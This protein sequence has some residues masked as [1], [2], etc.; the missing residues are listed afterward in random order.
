MA[1]SAA[2]SADCDGGVRRGV[3]PRPGPGLAAALARGAGCGM[4]GI[5]WA[6][7]AGRMRR[8]RVK[9]FIV[10][11][12]PP[13]FHNSTAIARRS[14]RRPFSYRRPRAGA[15]S[16][17]PLLAHTAMLEPTLTVNGRPASSVN[18]SHTRA[19]GASSS[20]GSIGLGP[21]TEHPPRTFP[22]SRPTSRWITQAFSSPPLPG[23]IPT[24]KPPGSDMGVPNPTAALNDAADPTRDHDGE[25]VASFATTARKR[26]CAASPRNRGSSAI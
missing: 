5:V 25:S 6:N 21:P 8:A 17:W 4:Q 20:A 1:I 26:G 12:A 16:K 14:V 18:G 19:A 7:T 2:S 9:I 24:G 22:A 15:L 10:S 3:G 13:G 23:T 11:E